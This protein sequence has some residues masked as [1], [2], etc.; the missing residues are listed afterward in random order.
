MKKNYFLTISLL[1][2]LTVNCQEYL[3]EDFDSGYWPPTW[4]PTGWT[5]SP[6]SEQWNISETAFAGGTIPEACIEG[7][8]YNGIV[9]LVSPV[10]DLSGADTLIIS[11]RHFA[12]KNLRPAPTL[13]F[14]TRTQH[15]W[16][17][18]WENTLEN[19]RGPEELARY[20]CAARVARTTT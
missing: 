19:D 2:A 10:L 15:F 16:H 14:A 8:G 1:L 11:F 9:R 18:V 5:T 6:T 13:G 4:P 3:S 12:D 20:R 17:S 7:F